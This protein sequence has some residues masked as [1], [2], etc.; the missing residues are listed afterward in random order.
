LIR[1]GITAGLFLAAAVGLNVDATEEAAAPRYVRFLF[2]HHLERDRPTGFL[3]FRAALPIS[4]PGRQRVRRVH[5]RP[6]PR[7]IVRAGD[8]RYAVWN[9]GAGRGD[10]EMRLMVEVEFPAGGPRDTRKPLSIE[11]RIRCLKPEPGIESDHPRIRET[12][13][14]IPE[15]DTPE[16][17][18]CGILGYVTRTLEYTGYDLEDQGALKAL[19][20]GRGDCTEYTDLFVALC[21][22][23][24]FPARARFCVL[25]HTEDTPL[26][27]VAEVYLEKRGW[28]LVDP[29]DAEGKT[30]NHLPPPPGLLLL[31]NLRNDPEMYHR[32][33]S[34]AAWIQGD[35]E[36]TALRSEV[37]IQESDGV[38]GFT[39]LRHRYGGFWSEPDG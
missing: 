32:F 7:E 2:T 1:P 29:L 5:T 22:S 15:E 21:R 38:G 20:R 37:E 3:R 4:E 16:A 19:V 8:R 9:V 11:D 12:A 14:A 35:I 24:G 6:E 13:A 18:V 39:T 25:F 10:V 30:L 36:P 28:V 33:G 17:T 27:T 31:C 34:T 23:K 26:H